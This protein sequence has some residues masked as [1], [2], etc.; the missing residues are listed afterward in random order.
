VRYVLEGSV[1]QSGD[2]LRVSA[3]LIDTESR[4]HVWAQT[5][6]GT[7]S[8]IFAFEDRIAEAV[9]G[10]LHP[11]IRTAEIEKAKRKPPG[12][13]VAYD[14]V[15]RS[16]PLLWSHRPEANAEATR[17]LD[18]AF[19]LDRHYARAAAMAAWARAQQVVFNWASDVP[20]VRAEG[21][22]LVEM[23]ADSIGDDPTALT[24]VASAAMLLSGDLDRTEALIDRALMLDPNHSWAWARRGFLKV[25]RGD[26]DTATQCFERAIRLS[27][28]DPYSFNCYVGLGLARFVAGDPEKAAEW[29]RRA[30]LEKVGM[31]WA[32]RDLA[33][34]LGA[35][36]KSGEARAALSELRK[37]YPDITIDKVAEAL[38]YMEPGLRG[39]YLDGLR[40]A[41]LAE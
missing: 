32:N 25:Y 26:A 21:Q 30:M 2:Q 3:Q 8:D 41:G 24:A 37:A 14:L 38:S 17:Y 7:I 18:E 12:N 40:A 23:V 19:A 6:N 35:A 22:R 31:T 27:P 15:L 34:F 28:L 9:A 29:T 20:R 4:A 5:F 33:A 11:S 36:G 13:L 39:R 16:L 10:A 1:R